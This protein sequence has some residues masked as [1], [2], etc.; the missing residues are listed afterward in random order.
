MKDFSN[1]LS[2][3]FLSVVF[4]LVTFYL[5]LPGPEKV[6][7]PPDSIQSQEP[8]DT[9]D[10]NLRAYFTN[11]TRAQVMAFY[12]DN[13]S[14]SSWANILLPTFRLNLPPED[15]FTVIQD[16]TKSSYL[17]EIV[18]PLRESLYVNGWQPD[19]D[20]EAKIFVDDKQFSTKVTIHRLDSNPVVRL[21]LLLGVIMAALWLNREAGWIDFGRFKNLWALIRK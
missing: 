13:F 14:R 19:P 12:Q 1:K 17:E 4:I 5:F 9:Q 21:A 20:R 3:V 11:Y 16:Q 7:G 15:A 6:P 18:H 2:K 8:G 10:P